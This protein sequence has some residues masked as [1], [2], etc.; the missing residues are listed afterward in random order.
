MPRSS[1]WGRYSAQALREGRSLQEASRAWRAAN[2]DVLGANPS[3]EARYHHHRRET[4]GELLS[5]GIP[6]H[7]A[8][9]RARQSRGLGAEPLVSSRDNP[10]TPSSNTWLIVGA[11]AVAAWYLARSW[12]TGAP[13]TV[14]APSTP[15]A[16]V[17][18]QPNAWGV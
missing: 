11:I 13:S 6:F 9:R 10:E 17:G 2:R 18:V 5:R 4:V 3:P 12:N 7:E 1:D 14:P 16:T 15:P 8:L